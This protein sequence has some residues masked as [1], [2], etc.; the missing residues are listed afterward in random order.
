MPEPYHQSN[1][2]PIGLSILTIQHI[3][4]LVERSV[5]LIP[6]GWEIDR[7]VLPLKAMRPHKVHLFCNP[8]SHPFQLHFYR[9]VAER[10]DRLGIQHELVRVDA[11]ADLM[12]LLRELSRCMASEIQAGNRVYV[13]ISAAGRIAAVAATLVSMA[14][15]EGHGR[16]YYVRPTR[17]DPNEEERMRHGLSV[18][19]SG[20]PV[21]VPL[22]PLRLPS[23]EGQVVLREL[24]GR[25][26]SARYF[27]LFAALQHAGVEGYMQVEK[28]TSRGLKGNLTVRLTKTILRPLLE[29]H[30]VTTEK[31][32]RNTVVH[33]THGGEY[34][35]NM[36]IGPLGEPALSG[37]RMKDA[38]M[39]AGK[40]PSKAL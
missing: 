10:L 1:A 14:H 26:G 31:K 30:L 32:G 28:G 27:D 15:L 36:L 22:F 4:G 38:L 29:A 13:N 37:S 12:G 11:N 24:E 16:A 19:M 25:G 6:L 3:P 2:K 34:M 7:A 20:D 9:Q 21:D 8:E 39:P 17:Y 5:H 18:G 33:L 35:A 23:P 40:H